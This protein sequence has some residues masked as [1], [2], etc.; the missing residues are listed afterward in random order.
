MADFS[1]DFFSNFLSL[2]LS[3][4]SS[5]TPTHQC[6][7]SALLSFPRLPASHFLL[8]AII[9]PSSLRPPSCPCL[10]SRLLHLQCFLSW[11]CNFSA[12]N[13]FFSVLCSHSVFCCIFFGV[14][15]FDALSP[16]IIF[17]SVSVCGCAFAIFLSA[18]TFFL[19]NYTNVYVLFMF[20][21]AIISVIITMY[22]LSICDRCRS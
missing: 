1:S 16:G 3:G 11:M 6:H 19:Y 21:P 8:S 22:H 14:S 13:C 18:G 15:K 20:K 5:V 10:Q 2:S 4:D 9:P 7:C 17:L 12:P